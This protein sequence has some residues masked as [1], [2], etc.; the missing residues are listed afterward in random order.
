MVNHILICI[1]GIIQLKTTD[2]LNGDLT[3]YIGNTRN[4][5]QIATTRNATV[6]AKHDRMVFIVYAHYLGGVGTV[7]VGRCVCQQWRPLRSAAA[8]DHHTLI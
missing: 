3:P 2:D 5:M 4:V 6:V 1:I 7:T 8:A